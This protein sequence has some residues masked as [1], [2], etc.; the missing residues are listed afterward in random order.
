MLI[1]GRDTGLSILA[2][3]ESWLMDGTYDIPPSQFSQ[4]YVIRAAISEHM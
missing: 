4:L 3:S 2:D 1:F